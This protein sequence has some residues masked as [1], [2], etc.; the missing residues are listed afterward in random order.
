MVGAWRDTDPKG[1][2][3]LNDAADV[4]AKY[5]LFAWMFGGGIAPDK[6]PE[7]LRAA[8]RSQAHRLFQTD[9]VLK[10][11]TE[12]QRQGFVDRLIRAQVGDILALNANAGSAQ[13]GPVMNE[14]V[15]Q[16]ERE[17]DLDLLKLGLTPDQ[18]FVIRK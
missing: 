4:L 15:A 1:D 17:F 13:L 18:G 5:W 14:I 11:L 7:P 3:R 16:F 10:S 2:Y 12:G 6:L 8:V 9:P